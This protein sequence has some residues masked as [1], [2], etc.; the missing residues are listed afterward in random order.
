VNTEDLL[1]RLDSVRKHPGHWTARCP[2]HPD[3]SPSLSVREM[4]DGI[5]VKCFAGCDTEAIARAVGVTKADLQ[6]DTD[7]GDRILDTYDYLDLD[8]SLLFQVVRWVPKKFTQ[9]RPKPGGGWLASLDK[10]KRVPY[11][12]PELREAID[13]GRQVILVEGERDADR[14]A[15][16]GLMATTTPQGAA[17]WRSEYAAYFKGAVSV[18]IIGDNDPPGEAYAAAAAKDLSAHV[19]KVR[20]VA[21]P[22]VALGGD[23][24]DWM[25]S[26][27]RADLE[28]VILAT[29]EWGKA[30]A[31][32]VRE[33]PGRVTLT[34]PSSGVEI[35]IDR[36]T[37]IGGYVHAEITVTLAETKLVAYQRVNVQSASALRDLAAGLRRS[38]PEITWDPLLGHGF[39][40][41]V[42]NFRLPPDTVDYMARLADPDD[43]GPEPLRWLAVDLWPDMRRGSLLFGDASSSKSTLG[44][45]LAVSVA[46][47]AEL[48]PGSP[49]MR[50]GPVLYLDW[51]D[52]GN[53]FHS[54]LRQIVRGGRLDPKVSEAVHYL[55][56]KVPLIEAAE[57]FAEMIDREGIAGVVIDSR[58]NA[59]TGSLV[60]DDD[61]RAFF[62]AIDHLGAPPLIID[63]LDKAS[64]R[65]ATPATHSFGSVFTRGRIASSW[66]VRMIRKGGAETVVTLTDAKWNHGPNRATRTF[67]LDWT[68]GLVVQR[69]AMALGVDE[70]EEG[71]RS[72]GDEIAQLLEEHPP[73]GLTAAE[74]ADL[75]GRPVNSIYK[76][77]QRLPRDGRFY[78][79]GNRWMKFPDVSQG[80]LP[81]PM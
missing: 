43:P 55:R 79:V 17:A 77:L 1:S 49:P 44:L 75:L 3:H 20:V 25:K 65:S 45:V 69:M 12:L 60:A 18:A 48:V 29:P 57:I 36:I 54:R 66:N 9:R 81:D 72:I 6:V 32:Q 52:D 34:W 53:L 8:G 28:K 13:G 2:A 27:D 26:H 33:R 73:P 14:L 38:Q 46:S 59:Q 41:A 19:S 16:E 76:A 70:E 71:R 10:T 50:T 58:G 11:R 63:H 67:V 24:S 23:I 35:L 51:E 21:L 64:V 61:T 4:D 42:E 39:T 80:T 22:D 31:P 15:R 56:P 47:G 7:T 40:L 68:E 62:D 30:S 74:M 5:A 78:K 37:W